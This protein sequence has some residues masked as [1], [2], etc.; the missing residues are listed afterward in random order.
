MRCDTPAQGRD[1]AMKVGSRTNCHALTQ[2][3]RAKVM[4]D[5][6]MSKYIY[7]SNN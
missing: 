4:P 7:I 2:G 6:F 3:E 1:L 5:L